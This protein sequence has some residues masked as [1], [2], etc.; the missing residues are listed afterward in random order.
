[1]PKH[2]KLTMYIKNPIEEVLFGIDVKSLD[3]IS[4]E[5]VVIQLSKKKIKFIRYKPF[6]F[7]QRVRGKF[8]I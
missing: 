1:M 2:H 3:F 5:K 8:I 4:L 7:W 6:P